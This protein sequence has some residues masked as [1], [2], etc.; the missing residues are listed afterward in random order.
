MLIVPTYREGGGADVGTVVAMKAYNLLF[1]EPTDSAARPVGWTGTA[2]PAIPW[3]RGPLTGLPMFH[4]LTLR[5]PAEYQRRGPQFPGIAFFQGE[6]QFAEEIDRTD[7]T[8]PFLVQWAE[9][10]PHPQQT[11]LTDIIDGRFAL[12]WLTE[13][14]LAAGPTAPPPDVRRAGE[15]PDDEG[16]N[17]WDMQQP[18]GGVW[19]AERNDPNAVIAPAHNGDGGYQDPFDSAGGE[20][21]PWAEPLTAD[22]HL[23]GTG[24]CAQALPE[25]LTPFYLELSELPGL[26]LGGDGNAQIDLESSVFDWACG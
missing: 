4:A 18:T 5:L 17:A 1:E 12:V 14:E 16:P 13:A 26:N 24:S 9:H 19:L 11:L 22:D 2:G 7:P 3:P 10:T 21:H 8:D 20:W 15:H 6:G 23:G 25:G